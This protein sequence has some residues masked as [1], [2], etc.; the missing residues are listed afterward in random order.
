MSAHS[1]K[2]YVTDHKIPQLFEVSAAPLSL[3][4]TT[5]MLKGKFSD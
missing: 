5:A 2:E 4:K 1:A 3:S